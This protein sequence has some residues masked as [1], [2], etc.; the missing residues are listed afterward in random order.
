MILFR[1]PLLKW[2]EPKAVKDAK[3]R[4]SVKSWKFQL[5]YAM[6]LALMLLLIWSISSYSPTNKVPPFHVACLLAF[7][8]AIVMGYVIPWLYRYMESD[9][10]LYDNR[11]FLLLTHQTC[12]FNSLDTCEIRPF[13]DEFNKDSV[14]VIKPYEG[15][16]FYI[17]IE[18]ALTDELEKTLKSIHVHVVRNNMPLCLG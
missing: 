6:V 15:S 14:L 13:M 9:I 11:I 1:K 3:D 16:P 7:L 4:L 2:R 10:R 18:S 17:G 8:G 12:R 5:A